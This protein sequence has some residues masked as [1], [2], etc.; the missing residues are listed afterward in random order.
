[1]T[2]VARVEDSTQ[3]QGGAETIIRRIAE[4]ANAVGRQAGVGASELAGQI[5]SCLYANPE[6]IQRF[7]DEGTELFIDG[8]FSPENGSL[9][10]LARNGNVV[11]P[12]VL[13]KT[14]GVQQ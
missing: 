6:H 11:S 9:T 2:D 13:R 5:V 7:M 10:Y 8:T 1:M 12:S 14:K 3:S 4:V